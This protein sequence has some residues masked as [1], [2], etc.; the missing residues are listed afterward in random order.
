[1]KHA[2]ANMALM[3]KKNRPTGNSQQKP[4]RLVGLP[5]RIVEALEKLAKSRE[6]TITE[7]VK[8]ACLD[9]LTRLDLWPPKS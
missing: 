6:T 2:V 5:P 3:A 7:M 9:Y 8:A 1:M 4:R